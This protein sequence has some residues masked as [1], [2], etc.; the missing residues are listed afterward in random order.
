MPGL[1][2]LNLAPARRR[3]RH[4]RG[5]AGRLTSGPGASLGPANTKKPAPF[6][7]P[8]SVPRTGLEPARILL[9]T[10][11]KRACLPISPPGQDVCAGARRT[12][13]LGR[14]GV[15]PVGFEP[16]T[17]WLKASCS[18]QLSYGAGAR[19]SDWGAGLRRADD[20]TRA[21]AG[22]RATGA[23]GAPAKTAPPPASVRRRARPAPCPVPTDGEARGFP[24]AAQ[25][26][27]AAALPREFV[28]PAGPGAILGP[29]SPRPVTEAPP[30]RLRLTR[31]EAGPGR[32]SGPRLA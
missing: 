24:E 32:G 12:G 22:G 4:E 28:G 23:C 30:F 7:E 2:A 9:H 25:A 10:P 11:L 16:T 17:R 15:T 31:V 14:R 19:R 21:R 27:G 3:R 8:A 29:D 20:Q 5:W 18:D 13:P 1:A 6:L 26:H